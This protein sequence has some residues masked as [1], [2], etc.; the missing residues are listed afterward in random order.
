MMNWEKLAKEHDE[1]KQKLAETV[2]NALSVSG[3]KTLKVNKVWTEDALDSGE[4]VQIEIVNQF[5]EA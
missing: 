1:L 3:P 2:T 4:P 5:E